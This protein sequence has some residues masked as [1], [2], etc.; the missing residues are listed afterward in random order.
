MKA[1]EYVC[2]FFFNPIGCNVLLIRKARPAWMAGRLNGVG[3]KIELGETN[4]QAMTRE[5]KEEAG[6][7]VLPDR[8]TAFASLDHLSKN[9]RIFFY[10]ATA[11]GDEVSRVRHP[12]D[13][14]EM[15]VWVGLDSIGRASYVVPNLNWLIPM[16]A[17]QGVNA[18][19]TDYS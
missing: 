18:I 16:A 5:F 3:G 9:T 7:T 10:H 1:T 17:Q 12:S 8:W 19:I 14:G 2:G 11:N 15:L 4:H 13:D 6:I